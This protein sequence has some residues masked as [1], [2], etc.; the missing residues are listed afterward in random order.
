MQLLCKVTV[1]GFPELGL[2]KGVSRLP[3]L[4]M[5]PSSLTS[6]PRLPVQPHLHLAG[7]KACRHR[8]AHNTSLYTNSM[9]LPM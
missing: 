8:A 6:S 7:L 9:A 1:G 2:S 4:D 3:A 5:S